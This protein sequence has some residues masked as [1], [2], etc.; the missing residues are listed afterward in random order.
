M[1]FQ[2]GS[3]DKSIIEEENLENKSRKDGDYM[4]ERV[5]V[6]DAAKEIGC[7]PQ[8]LRLQMATGNWDLGGYVK[9]KNKKN[10][11]YYVFRAKLDKFLG[12]A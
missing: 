7:A 11:S 3:A 12:K 1:I 4:S 10:G 8:Y 5:R 6:D 2:H 9:P